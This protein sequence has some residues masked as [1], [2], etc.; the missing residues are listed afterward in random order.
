M[1]PEAFHRFSRTLVLASAFRVYVNRRRGK[2]QSKGLGKPNAEQMDGLDDRRKT[3]RRVRLV[4]VGAGHAH[5]EIIRRLVHECRSS[6]S[7]AE[8]SLVSLSDKHH[9][10]GMVPGYLRGAY[11]EDE[12]AFDL[13]PLARAA[14][15]DFIGRRAL[16]VDTVAR[17]VH[18]EGGK[19]LAYDLASFNLGSRAAG[20]EAALPHAVLVKPMSQAVALRRRIL[21]LVHRGSREDRRVVVVGGGSAGVEVACAIAAVMDEAQCRRDVW[22][23]EASGRML[24][25]YSEPFRLSAERVLKEKGIGVRTGTRVVRVHRDAVELDDGSR[26]PSDLTVWLTGPQG[27]KLFEGSGL[28]LDERGFLLVD[29]SLRSLSDPAIF[30]VGDCATLVNHPDTPKAGVYAVR[31]APILWR[32]LLSTIGR[33]ALPRYRPQE[34]FLSLL[35]TSDGRALL[36]YKGFV[37]YNRP[38][39][40]LKDWIDRRFMARYRNLAQE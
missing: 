40:W 6:D 27:P 11:R 15:G 25:T 21:Q 36:S 19:T 32:S 38:A 22:I 2:N 39:W 5:L 31:Q 24:A 1:A 20:E 18:L 8:L 17:V 13:P 29:D 12:I 33:G 34:G 7:W 3:H 35:N 16:G 30:G 10:S 28:D 26:K 23:L 14:G 4:L 37:S 9:Y